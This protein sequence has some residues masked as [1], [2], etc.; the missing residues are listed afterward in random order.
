MSIVR[1]N[2]LKI[3]PQQNLQII[4]GRTVWLHLPDLLLALYLW[5]DCHELRSVVRSQ[6]FDAYI[7]KLH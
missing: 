1:L 3:P 6:Q 4:F 7:C 5:A 2:R